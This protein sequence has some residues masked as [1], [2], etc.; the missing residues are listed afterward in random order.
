MANDSNSKQVHV[1][2]LALDDGRRMVS[3]THKTLHKLLGR[4]MLDWVI[5]ALGDYCTL[6]DP[7]VIVGEKG[8][9]LKEYYGD[10]L[11]Y[12]D[13]CGKN[14][15]DAL[16]EA[17]NGLDDGTALI[18]S[19]D[20]P[21]ISSDTL[22]CLV[23]TKGSAA[24]MTATLAEPNGYARV[25]RRDGGEVFAIFDEDK[26]DKTQS[27]QHEV[28]VPAYCLNIGALKAAISTLDAQQDNIEYRVNDIINM[29]IAVGDKINTLPVTRVEAMRVN[30]RVQLS[31]CCLELKRRINKKHM[32]KGVTLIDPECAY[33]DETVKL[34]R[35]CIIYPN[36][37]LEGN[38][39]I[40]EGS[41]LYPGCR[42]INSRFGNNCK[43]QAVVANE[44]IVGDNVTL[45]PYVN[46]RSGAKLADNVK[47]G[48]YIEVK[49]ATV[50]EGSKLPHLSYIGDGEIGKNV[51]LGCGTVFVNYDGYK[52]HVTKIGDNS[53]IGCHTSLV[54]PVN[55]GAGSF[56]AAGSV[57]TGDVPDD[58]LAIARAKQVNKV[59]YIRRLKIKRGEI[60]E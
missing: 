3:S 38:T 1:I 41:I 57:I 36:V 10:S 12:V 23:K 42:I 53:F 20:M 60:R 35:D 13:Q 17:T 37:V 48:N 26:L 31:Q 59:G 21:L 30:D 22:D 11:Q 44:A 28:C 55:V 33:I 50:G 29:M 56:T 24:F 46:L 5:D 39:Y 9:Q 16:L 58:T 2:L 49:N 54:A 7:I 40:G 51:N 47:V 25:M 45:G 18:I 32:L 52:K 19:A 15:G 43:L 6:S 27:M 14:I 4:S 8:E 34:S